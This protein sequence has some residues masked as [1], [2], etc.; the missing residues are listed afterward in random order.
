MWR[1]NS[2][3]NMLSV[4]TLTTRLSRPLRL[5][6]G[7]RCP[8]YLHLFHADPVSATLYYDRFGVGKSC[9]PDDGVNLVQSPYEVPQAI[10]I[11]GMLR[12]GAFEGIP[13]YNTVV[14]ISH[15]AG[16]RIVTASAR[17]APET[18][19]GVILT[20]YTHNIT[21]T[22]LG[23]AG[24]ANS[25]ANYIYPDRFGH[26]S[27]SYL[28]TPSMDTDHQEWF[29]WPNF[30]ISALELFTKEQKGTVTYGQSSAT[31]ALPLVEVNGVYDKPT[32][33]ITGNEDSLFCEYH[34]RINIPR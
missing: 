14:A 32:F 26:L 24:F 5:M 15:S 34:E 12:E 4:D 25:M 13:A 20:G 31:F 10:N 7:V 9:T 29:H 11:A 22:G 6:A 16:A 21:T 2:S 18:W 27:N 33:I 17:H 30:T 8:L 23:T 3:T 19:D 1:Q 28:I